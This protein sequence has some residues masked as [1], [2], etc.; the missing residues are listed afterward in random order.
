M[1]I[2]VVMQMQSA[3]LYISLGMLAVAAVALGVWRDAIARELERERK[4]VTTQRDQAVQLERALAVARER[5]RTLEEALG[6]EGQRTNALKTQMTEL[7]AQI[8]DQ[9]IERG[10][11]QLVQLAGERFEAQKAEVREE[12][13]TRRSAIDAVLTP[14]AERLLSLDKKLSEMESQREGAYV[15]VIEQVTA[16]AQATEQLRAGADVLKTETVKLSSSLRN[17]G[18]RGRWGEFQLRR[19]VEVAGMIDYC[20][21][22]EQLAERDDLGLGRPDMTIR[23]PNGQKI[24]VD[25]KVPLAN[26]L[27][28]CEATEEGTRSIALAAH[29]RA[30]FTYA[31]ELAK[32]DYTRFEA[33]SDFVVMFVPNEAALSAALIAEPEL[34]D[35]AISRGVYIVGPLSLVALLRAYAAGWIVVRQEQNAREIAQTGRELYKRLA[36]FADHLG[37]VGT[38]LRNAT[39]AFN[40]AVGSYR[41]R[42]VPQARR[43]EDLGANEA[44]KSVSE[45]AEIDTLAIVVSATESL[46]AAEAVPA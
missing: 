37:R 7:F 4:E 3:V 31:N 46:P 9:Q 27:D 33:M 34:L 21:F 42:L 32:R 2:A 23:I 25:A 35:K 22:S 39:A 5:V 6:G 14:F 18:A 38:G 44:S 12:L 1:L 24:P 16:L 26:Y 11:T 29:A 10:T 13:E 41:D 20:D 17:S 8:G 15:Q 40:S 45:L 30:V 43:F 28:A 36:I 19:I